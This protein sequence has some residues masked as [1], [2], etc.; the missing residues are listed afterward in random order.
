MIFGLGSW[1]VAELTAADATVPPQ[2]VGFA[3]SIL[4]WPRLARATR[5]RVPPRHGRTPLT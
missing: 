3:F 4:A 1:G 5:A 2:L